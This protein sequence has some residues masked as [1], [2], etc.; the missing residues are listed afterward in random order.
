MDCVE[1]NVRLS[2]AIPA[3]VLPLRADLSVDIPAYR[4]HLDH[5]AGTSGVGGVVC[6]G[7]AAEV[8]SLSRE[9]RR[10]AVAVAVETVAG[11]V[12]VIAG[13][14]A[15]NYRDAIECARDAQF[16]GAD[17]LLVFPAPVLGVG[18]DQGMAYR[19]IAEV[20][21]AVSLPVVV[22]AY[23]SF[24]GM[25]YA[26]RTLAR[27][28]ELDAVVAVK[29]WSLDLRV[30]ENTLEIVRG[31]GHPVALLTSFSTNLLPA[32]AAGA[33]GIL[34][35][36]GSVIANLHA[37]LLCHVRDNELAAA[38]ALYGRIQLLTRVIYRDPMANMYARMK[39]HLI[40]LGHNMSPAVRP[41]LEP[42]SGDERAEL[43]RALVAAGLLPEEG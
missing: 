39:E 30:H 25:A 37:Q 16:E 28:C 5:L 4:Q 31:A 1:V 12:P 43:R 10:L 9:E 7:H 24:T 20:A 36:H 21:S 23:P 19:H 17:G 40:M 18:G 6:N 29:E 13:V 35:G 8:T 33:D 11:R 2:G 14:H 22:F 32:L 42:V 34:S 15:D 41:P 26:P 38:Q 27:L 3:N